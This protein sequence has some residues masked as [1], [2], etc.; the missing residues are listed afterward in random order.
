MTLYVAVGALLVLLALRAWLGDR[1]V[2][3]SALTVAFGPLNRVRFALRR[4]LSFSRGAPVLPNEPKDGVFAYL[5][6][7]ALAKAEARAKELRATYA[8]AALEA[9][10]T[11]LAYRENL[12][13]TDLLD[14]HA[15]SRMKHANAVTVVDVG[16]KDFVYA[17]A[18]LAFAARWSEAPPDLTGV[19][20][21]G[22]V[23]Y[24][25]L[26]SRADHATAWAKVAGPTA[27]YRVQ[28]FL[29]FQPD[30][31]VQLL[32]IFYPFV[33]RFALLRWGL[34]VSQYRPEALLAHAA[35]M[36]DAHGVLVIVNHTHEERGLLRALMEKIEGV[37]LVH[38]GDVR[39]TLV[40]YFEDVPERSVS[41]YV[42]G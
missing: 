6:G 5:E 12:Y 33:T 16:S 36:L 39:S 10:S 20:L 31:P 25:D 38:T 2:D 3:L 28:D 8:L 15:A 13:V 41:V 11:L 34:P 40:D 21:D 22:Y 29:A 35:G 42:R 32:T 4:A 17:P 18:L 1:T 26:H 9:C 23:V 27:R 14:T 19:E 24:K 7:D 30:A 37:A